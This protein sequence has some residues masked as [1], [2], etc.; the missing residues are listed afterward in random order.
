[1]STPERAGW[2]DDPEDESQLRYFDGIVWSDHA[3]P[4][5]VPTPAPTP[6]EPPGGTSG[7]GGPGTDVF[8]RVG[9]AAPQ[10]PRPPHGQQQTPPGWGPTA[11]STES[12]TADGQPLAG[13][14]ARAGAYLIDMLV[15]GIL[16]LL[17]AGWAL[18][19]WMADYWAFVWDAAQRGDSQAIDGLSPEELLGFF[20][21]RYYFLYLGISLLVLAAY[22]IGFLAA[23]SATPG[24]MALGLS[25]RRTDHPGR[26]GAGTAFMRM[27]LPL[28]VGVFSAVPLLSYLVG[29]V[30]VVDLL[31]PIKDT[32][33]QALHDKI[34]G[35]QVVK[36]KQPRERP[37]QG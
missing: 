30:S 19:L 1:M 31:W 10:H 32:R 33:Q 36:G 35:T 16:N 24:K 20:E 37:R 12:T 2:Y 27:L 17:F 23:R 34:A 18:W 7:H 26:I 6:Q 8:G 11:A 15:V 29:L 13:Y 21:W 14:G 3:V 9:G 28:G 25:V 5:R 4:K 22:H